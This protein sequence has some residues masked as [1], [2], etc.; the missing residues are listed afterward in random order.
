MSSESQIEL[1]TTSKP[2]YSIRSLLKKVEQTS[3]MQRWNEGLSHRGGPSAEASFVASDPFLMDFGTSVSVNEDLR[4][5]IRSEIQ[6]IED[7]IVSTKAAATVE[8]RAQAHL[9]RDLNHSRAE[10]MNLS[11]GADEQVENARVHSSFVHR[12]EE[13]LKGELA[14]SISIESQK[15]RQH[16]PGCTKAGLLLNFDII[17]EKSENV[18][19][20]KSLAKENLQFIS[21]AME[22]RKILEDQTS[23]ILNTIEADKLHDGLE[24]ARHEVDTQRR[25]SEAEVERMNKLKAAIQQTRACCGSNA[26]RVA[27]SVSGHHLEKM[28]SLCCLLTHT[29]YPIS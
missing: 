11:R 6:E 16:N 4:H 21:S 28:R 2:V 26:K 1:V 29:M 9:Q 22:Q 27:D 24:N 18:K 17:K 5:A 12:V 15:L 13:T 25:D 10:M 14:Q 20:L 3:T 23:L 7:S 19:G 8:E